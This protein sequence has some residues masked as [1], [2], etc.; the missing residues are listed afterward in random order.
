MT[1]TYSERLRAVARP[2]PRSSCSLGLLEQIED[3]VRVQHQASLF[4]LNGRTSTTGPRGLLQHRRPVRPASSGPSRMSDFLVL[5]RQTDAVGRDQH[6]RRLDFSVDGADIPEVDQ[7]RVFNGAGPPTTRRCRHDRARSYVYG[8]ILALAGVFVLQ[9]LGILMLGEQRRYPEGRLGD[10]RVEVDALLST[11]PPTT[12]THHP[13]R[14]R[15]QDP[16][17]QA[18]AVPDS[19]ALKFGTLVH[20][21][22]LEPAPAHEYVALDP[23]K[24][25]VK[26]T[27]PRRRTRP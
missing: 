17:R 6:L 8:G 25:G 14:V 16:P 19:D 15:R 7:R 1:S 18:P 3:Q 5:E 23:E 22:V 11:R 27:A 13:L 24:I 10:F 26:P 4:H 21:A 20:V 9:Q 2:R 12:P